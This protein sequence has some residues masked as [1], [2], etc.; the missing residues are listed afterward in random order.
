[1]FLSPIVASSDPPLQLRSQ[2]AVQ[3]RA[4]WNWEGSPLHISILSPHFVAAVGMA[5]SFDR[6]YADLD[7]R[8]AFILCKS[9]YAV[10]VKYMLLSTSSVLQLLGVCLNNVS[11][12]Y[13]EAC[14]V[15]LKQSG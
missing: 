9:D 4:P 3:E 5:T 11:S 7:V 2:L 12:I 10:P 14:T 13:L 8:T 15:I 1:M 6:A